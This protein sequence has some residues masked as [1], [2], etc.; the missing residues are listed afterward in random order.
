[1]CVIGVN[2]AATSTPLHRQKITWRAPNVGSATQYLVYRVQG[3]SVNAGNASSLTVVATVP[4]APGVI[5][6]AAID[7]QELPNGVN[8]TYFVR[9]R[10][11]DG[12]LSAASNFVTI[13]AVNDAPVANA[14]SYNVR[15]GNTLSVP[16]RGVLANTRTTTAPSP[17]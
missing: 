1:M 9:A 2:C 11:A 3:T 17:R 14:D 15:T 16:A 4:P 7:T 13:T 6:Y 10:F 5:A 12:N 8:Y